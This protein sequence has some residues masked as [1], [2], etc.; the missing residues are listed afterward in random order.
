LGRFDGKT[1]SQEEWQC[2]KDDVSSLQNS[3]NTV[4]IEESN[5]QQVQ[6]KPSVIGDDMG[7]K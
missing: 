3:L 7:N 5:I 2:L 6:D 4:D 1:L